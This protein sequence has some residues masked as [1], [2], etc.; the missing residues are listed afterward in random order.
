MTRLRILAPIALAAVLLTACSSS[1]APEDDR[2]QVV[3]SF[4]PLAWAAEQV[5]GDRVQVTDLTPPGGEAH[6]AK[7]TAEQRAELGSADLVLIHGH[8]GF[9]PEIEEGG[10][11]GPPIPALMLV[12]QGG[13]GMTSIPGGGP[14]LH[15]WLDPNMMASFVEELG[16]QLAAIDPEGRDGY[17]SRAEDLGRALQQLAPD[18][19][20]CGFGS[21]VTSREAFGYLLAAFR[22]DGLAVQQVGIEGAAPEGEPSATRV[23]D[24]LD[25]ISSGEAPRVVFAEPSDEGRRV[26]EAIAADADATVTA[27]NPLET[28]PESGDYLS[29]MQDNYDTL[30]KWMECGP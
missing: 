7:L 17:L 15:L 2:L 28:A 21:A 25:V 4:Y 13:R 8:V 30:S 9:Q 27:L 24:A 18:E 26:A 11:D 10:L 14:D 1:A 5:G 29:V 20:E 23:Q 12:G 22:H 16:E 3:A 19:P 6:D